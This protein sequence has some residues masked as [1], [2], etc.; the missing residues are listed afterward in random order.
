[1]NVKQ[2]IE[3]L[4][5]IQDKEQEVVFAVQDYFTRYSFRGTPYLNT[6]GHLWSGIAFNGRECQI[7]VSLDDKTK[8]DPETHEFVT[9]HPKVSFR[10]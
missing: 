7:F 9:V 10:K 5:Q 3:S 8:F 4:N 6:D 2:L 1:M